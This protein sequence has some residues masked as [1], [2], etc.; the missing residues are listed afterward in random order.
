MKLTTLSLMNDSVRRTS[1]SSAAIGCFL[2]YM[3]SSLT[4]S[5]AKFSW[6]ALQGGISIMSVSLVCLVQILHTLSLFSSDEKVSQRF[7]ARRRWWVGEDAWSWGRGRLVWSPHSFDACLTV[8]T[9]L[10]CFTNRRRWTTTPVTLAVWYA[11][12]ANEWTCV[13]SRALAS[14]Y[15]VVNGGLLHEVCP[16]RHHLYT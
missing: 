16:H 12:L 5:S 4:G 9:A 1:M 15:T 10:Y 13:C 6:N 11:G 2:Q 14:S 7:V 8:S 3:L